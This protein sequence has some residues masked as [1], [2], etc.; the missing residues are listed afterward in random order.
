[1]P[2]EPLRQKQVPAGPV[3][4]GHRGVPQRVEGIEPVESR[5]RLPGPEGELDA[6]LADADAGL[7]AEWL[8][9]TPSK[10]TSTG[11]SELVC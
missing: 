5:L 7:G 10:G 4:V 11:N 1:M 2:G 8:R 9:I 3:D 6:A